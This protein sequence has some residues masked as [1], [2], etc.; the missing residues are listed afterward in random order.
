MA[1]VPSATVLVV[2]LD[3]GSVLSGV[4]AGGLPIGKIETV[5]VDLDGVVYLETEGIPGAADALRTLEHHGMQILFATN[6]S[7]KTPEIAARHVHERS[8]YLA[9]PASIVTS[10][11]AAAS[12]LDGMVDTAL[13]IG[14]AAIGEA[15]NEVGIDVVDDWRHALAVVAGLDRALSY[16]GLAAGTQAIRQRGAILVATNTD[17]T[18]PTPQGLLPGG[19]A[20]VAAL[21][22]AGGVDAVVAGKPHEP[23]RDLIE[24][25]AVGAILVVGDRPETDIGLA[26]AQWS[27]ALVLSGVTTTIEEIPPEFTPSVVLDSIA[28]LPGVLGLT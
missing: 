13:I 4:V 15:L 19:G 21:E 25:K 22:R 2:R 24:S 14:S 3:W 20:M 26:G 28:A 1:L 23:M 7:T 27:S 17:A 16:D 12:L 10:G 5:V 11:Q 9:D 6:N 8:G 18:Y